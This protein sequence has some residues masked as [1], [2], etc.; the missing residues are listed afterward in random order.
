M[1]FNSLEYLIFLPCVFI[2]LDIYRNKDYQALILLVGSYFFYFYSAGNFIFVMGITTL[3]SYIAGKRIFETTDL[4]TKKIWVFISVSFLL[5]ML[6]Y[7]KYYEF[8][9]SNLNQVFSFS[10]PVSEIILPI[11]I[12]FYTFEA[13]SYIVDIYRGGSEPASSLKIYAL[14]IAFFPHLVAGPIVLSRELLPQIG[15]V[16]QIIPENLSYGAIRISWGLFKKIVIADNCAPLVMATLDS[17]IGHS[18][19]DIIIATFL[20]GIQIYCDFSGYCDIALGSARMIGIRLPEN[21]QLPYFSPSPAEFWRRWHMTLGRF[22]RN[23]VYIP[24]GG[25][26]KGA[27]RTYGNLI[28]SMLLCGLWHGAA[29]HFIFWGGYHG[30]CLAIHKIIEQIFS[31]MRIRYKGG[32]WIWS[33][34]VTQYLMFMG[35]I[36][37]RVSGIENITYCLEKYLLPDYL[38]QNTLLSLT[39][40]VILFVVIFLVSEKIPIYTYIHTITIT[41]YWEILSRKRP[42]YQI[43]FILVLAFFIY[44]FAP[45]LA[46]QFIY[47]QF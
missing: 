11:G 25:N 3:I 45:G 46:P 35:W 13:I 2:A 42:A 7:Y 29:W 19:V 14:Y 39:F 41:D 17:P 38:F 16:L 9:I 34:L 22:I 1:L 37:F 32:Y 10:F 31:F 6:G 36:F 5:L 44:L 27:V 21:F 4:R 33:L 8:F 20:F 47:F 15:K 26:R 23:Y 40:V 43:L 24:L 12:S 18:S 30:I 28:F